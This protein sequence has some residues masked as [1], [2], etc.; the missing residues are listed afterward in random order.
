MTTP[1]TPGVGSVTAGMTRSI[2]GE[3]TANVKLSLDGVKLGEVTDRL[4]Q[5]SVLG[6]DFD[7][8][9]VIGAPS[10]IQA[11][12]SLNYLHWK[13]PALGPLM[14]EVVLRG[15]VNYVDQQNWDLTQGA[16]LRFHLENTRLRNLELRFSVDYRIQEKASITTEGVVS[17]LSAVYRF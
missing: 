14:S 15:A 8:K 3:F 12:L 4:G 1:Q 9:Y 2:T 11:A 5:L 16:Q 13:M 10:P 17:N 7:I 6:G